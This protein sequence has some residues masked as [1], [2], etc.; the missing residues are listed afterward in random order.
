MLCIC[1][2]F[3]ASS[4]EMLELELANSKAL[5]EAVYKKNPLELLIAKRKQ[6]TDK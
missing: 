2:M 3:A 6:K 1:L 4:R 5:L